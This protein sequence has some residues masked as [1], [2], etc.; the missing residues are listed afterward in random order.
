MNKYKMTIKSNNSKEKS[1]EFYFGFD[2][3][4]YM[5]TE[6]LEFR[7]FNEKHIRQIKAGDQFLQ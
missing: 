7:K 1:E 2:P 6:E 3:S 5:F 4:F